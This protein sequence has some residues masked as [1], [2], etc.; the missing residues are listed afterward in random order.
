MITGRTG[1]RDAV[2]TNRGDSENDQQSD[3]KVGDLKHIDAVV[4]D[5]RAERHDGDGEQ[6]AHERNDWSKD[7]ERPVDRGRH[8]VFF[9]VELQP[10]GQGL[11]QA[12]GADAA[13]PEAV[14]NAADDLAFEQH[15]VGNAGQQNHQHHDDLDNAQ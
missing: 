8:D 2:N 13:W 12:E 3:V 5:V 15:G 14:L 11:K 7:I 1:E 4:L 10:V 6:C 9:E